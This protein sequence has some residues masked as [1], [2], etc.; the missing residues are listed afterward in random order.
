M[1]KFLFGGLICF[2]S[3]SQPVLSQTES[4]SQ[5]ICP[6]ELEPAINTLINRPQF[7]HSRWGILIETLTQ[8]RTLYNRDSQ[9]YFIPA[10]TVKLLTTAAAFQKLSANFRIRTSVYGDNQGNIYIVGRGDPSLTETQLKDLAQQ[11]KNKGISQ[12][13]Q[14]IAVDGYFT[15]S[16]IHSSWQ[17]EDIQ[18]GYG[19]PINSLILNQ[20]S[21]DLILSPQGVGQPLKVTW[22]RPEQATGWTVENQTKTVNKNEPEFVDI[23]R[24]LSKPIIRVSGQLRVGAEPEPVYAAVVEP[25]ENFIQVFKQVLLNSGIQVLQTSIAANFSYPPEELA[26][27]ESPPLSELIKTLNSESNNVFAESLLRTL[28]VQNSRSDSVESGLKEIQLMLTRLGVNPQ[29]YYLV[30]GSGLSQNNLVTPLALVQTLRLMAGSP[31]TELY[32]NS[33]PVAGISGTL[34][35]R[36]QDSSAVG[37]VQ[38]KTGTLTGVS[39]LAGYISP[40]D[41]Q[42]LVFSIMINQ[43]HLPTTELRKAIDEIVLLL[44]R[45]KSCP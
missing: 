26:F 21:L 40:P 29:G 6:T 10:S 14:L 39:S 37:I 43:T 32:Q 7:Q 11:L 24:D 8:G 17:W 19:A 44:T 3:L 16:P 31:V 12:I 22:V 33:L 20:N 27:V 25:T 35:G 2:L 9:Y 28:G 34:K 36:F 38:A 45:L 1:K 42:P 41:Y 18:S 13:N 15:G 4:S 5:K 30:D 23:G